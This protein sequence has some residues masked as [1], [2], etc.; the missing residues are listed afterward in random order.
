MHCSANSRSTV[1]PPASKGICPRLPRFDLGVGVCQ[2]AIDST[3]TLWLS[4]HRTGERERES[5]RSIVCDAHAFPTCLLIFFPNQTVTRSTSSPSI[6]LDSSA[7]YL[8]SSIAKAICLSSSQGGQS[9]P[10]IASLHH[11]S[12]DYVVSA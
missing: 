9:V 4:S 3:S 2:D 5:K 12:F 6:H 10:G 11:W 8:S 1:H 7:N